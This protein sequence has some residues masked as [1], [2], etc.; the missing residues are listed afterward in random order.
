VGQLYRLKVLESGIT[1]VE[2]IKDGII[3]IEWSKENE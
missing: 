1:K 2:V 3:V